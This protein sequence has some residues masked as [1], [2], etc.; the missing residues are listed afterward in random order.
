MASFLLSY[1]FA[2]NHSWG[3]CLS[4]I[5]HTFQDPGFFP[6]S[7]TNAQHLSTG[8]SLCYWQVEGRKEEGKF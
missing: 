3:G 8:K 7:K 4:S 5:L 6:S 1:D 2:Q